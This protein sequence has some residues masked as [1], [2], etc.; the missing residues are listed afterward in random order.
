MDSHAHLDFF[1]SETR[2]KCIANA[3]AEGVE[4]FVV[5]GVSSSGWRGIR[6]MA[7]QSGEGKVFFG[8][9]VHPTEV[10]GEENCENLGQELD[11]AVETVVGNGL[12]AIGEIGLDYYHLPNSGRDQKKAHQRKA[13]RVQIQVAKEKN[14]PL[15]IHCR[16]CDGETAAWKDVQENLEKEEFP[17]NRA[18]IHSFAYGVEE[19]EKWCAKGGYVSFSGIA[20][21]PFATA[22]REAI[23]R[24]PEGQ[25]LIETDSPY[26][27]PH[28][29]IRKDA[30]GKIPQNEPRNVVEIARLIQG[31][32][33]QSKG[34]IL[35]QTLTNGLRFFSIQE[36]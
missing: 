20:T 14:L 26:L 19:M 30:D 5:P 3:R 11:R 16:D 13:F 29:L 17:A 22:V 8:F 34:K 33:G 25:M 12:V 7:E 9:G 24:V 32:T 21:K 23:L 1:D 36:Q 18:L 4:Y 31:L 15:I 35:K 2:K 6:E 27:L 28:G 10:Q